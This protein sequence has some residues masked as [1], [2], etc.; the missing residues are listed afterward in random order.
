MKDANREWHHTYSVD[1]NAKP[2]FLGLSGLTI[3][4]FFAAVVFSLIGFYIMTQF[5]KIQLLS[6]LVIAAVF[7]AL[8]LGVSLRFYTNKPKNYAARWAE[9]QKLK[10]SKAPLLSHLTKDEN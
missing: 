6:S 4:A 10:K 7:P 3:V 2:M 1:A 8:V 9:Y 5:L